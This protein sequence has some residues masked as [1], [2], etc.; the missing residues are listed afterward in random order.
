MAP[1]NLCR[2]RQAAVSVKR[3]TTS[4]KLMDHGDRASGSRGKPIGKAPGKIPDRAVV[5]TVT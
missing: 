2:P 3:S 1:P 5:V 4:K